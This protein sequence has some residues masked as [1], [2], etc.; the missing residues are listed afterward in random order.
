MEGTCARRGCGSRQKLSLAKRSNRSGGS[1]VER[2]RHSTRP[3]TRRGPGVPRAASKASAS[4]DT[5]SKSWPNSGSPN[6]RYSPRL[7]GLEWQQARPGV[8]VKL[9]SEDDELYAFAERR[10]RIAKE[11]SMRLRQLKWLC[12]RLRQLHE[13]AL[14]REELLMRLGAT[15]FACSVARAPTAWRSVDVTV[16]SDAARFSYR[17]DRTKLRKARL[18][19]WRLSAAHQQGEGRSGEAVGILHPPGRR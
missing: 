5:S 12:G 2:G 17:L 1:T 16:E 3:L 18:R 14:P 11:R 10:E 19:E 15:S 13:M 8:Q 7:A 6:N 9:L 4:N